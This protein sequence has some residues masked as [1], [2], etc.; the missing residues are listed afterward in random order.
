MGADAE[1]SILDIVYKPSDD[2]ER[3]NDMISWDH[4]TISDTK[5]GKMVTKKD[6]VTNW[7]S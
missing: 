7:K 4:V 5:L 1:L 6:H 3:V 2:M